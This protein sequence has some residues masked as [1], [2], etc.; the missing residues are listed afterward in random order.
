MAERGETKGRVVEILPL[1][2][3]S[4]SFIPSLVVTHKGLD[5]SGLSF[6]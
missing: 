5:M 1:L 2:L 4:V 3:K 6:I